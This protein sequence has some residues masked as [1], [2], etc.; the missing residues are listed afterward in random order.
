MNWWVVVFDVVWI[1]FVA[2]AVIVVLR[3]SRDGRPFRP[4]VWLDR[5]SGMEALPR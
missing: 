5:W 4:D 2:P 3:D 1:W